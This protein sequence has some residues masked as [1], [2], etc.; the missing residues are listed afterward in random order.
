[1]ARLPKA[2][3][4][5][6]DFSSFTDKSWVEQDMFYNF[7]TERWKR[8][9]DFIR[10]LHWRTLQELDLKSVP[11]WK[12]FPIINFTLAFYSDYLAQF[13]QSRVRFSAV[14]DSADPSDIAAAELADHVLRYLWTKLSMDAKKID[15]AAWL[16]ATGNADMRVF[17]NTDTGDMIPLAVPVP[18][19]NGQISLV[20]VNPDTLQPDPSMPEPVLVDAGEIGV[21]VVPPQLVRW[22]PKRSMGAMVGHL[23][24]FDEAAERY[25]DEAANNLAYGRLTGSV[26]TDVLSVFPAQGGYP[27]TEEAALVI[28]HYLP[29]SS[30]YPSGLWWTASN[31]RLLTRPMPLPGR[32]VPIVHFRWVPVPGHNTMGLTPL[33]DLTFSNKSYDE[34][35]A[36]ILEWLNKVIPKVIRK[37]GDGLKYG[38]FND[39]PGQ[40]LV[41]QPGTE[42]GFMSPPAPPEHFFKIKDDIADNMQMVGGYKLRRPPQLP[43]GEATQRVRQP[44]KLAGE[45]EVVAL[46][47]INSKPAWE[48]LGYVLLDYVGKFY[49]ERRAFGIQGPDR[50]YQWR[51]F[52]GSDLANLPATLHV[53]EMPLYTWNRQSLRDT[54]IAILST[55]AAGVLFAGPDGQI[56]RERVNAAMEAAGIDVS[57]DTLDP[58]V[59]EARNE[60]HFF[61]SLPEDAE[62]PQVQSWQSDDVHLDEHKRELKSLSYRGWPPHAQQAFLEHVSQHEQRVSQA[63]QAAQEQMLTQ[64]KMLRDIRAQAETS[65]D[66]RTALGERLVDVLMDF[67]VDRKGGLPKTTD[68]NK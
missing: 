2:D 7:Y 24:T 67:L 13:L 65:Q 9:I 31:R 56:D 40:E 66:V 4:G 14:P 16:A 45:G 55:P 63:T 23:L 49:S 59:L 64:E 48:R 10:A 15:L 28:E 21:E 47:I 43:P 6:T 29:R 17:W 68:S 32:E 12:R 19:Q 35:M 18:M 39:Q 62:P 22:L 34:I 36:R 25:G 53:D 20:P 3:A 58:D 41:V 60:N 5:A 61:R 51:E 11:E 30:R 44:P 37:T 42:P 26:A 8:T 27:R 57:P 1:M 38:E 33:Y 46:A 50:T 54:V 52:V